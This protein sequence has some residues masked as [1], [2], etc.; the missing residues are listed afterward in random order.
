MNYFQYEI[1]TDNIGMH[2]INIPSAQPQLLFRDSY[3]GI[4]V[5]V[6]LVLLLPLAGSVGHNVAYLLLAGW[7]L[8]G[9]REALEALSLTWFLNFVN[10]G[11]Y[12]PSGQA[13]ML[14]W[15]VLGAAFLSVLRVGLL[16]PQSNRSQE[17][18]SGAW[19]GVVTFCSV[20][21]VLAVFSSYVPDVSISMLFMFFVGATTVLFG[22]ALTAHLASYWERWFL[23]FFVVI[24]AVSFPLIVHD[25][26]YV[27]NN[28]GFQGLTDHP[29]TYGV[30]LA[31][32]LSWMVA[33][34]LSGRLRGSF[35]WGVAAI[36]CISLVATQ[37]RTGAFAAVLGFTCI[38]GLKYIQ[39]PS[40]R[41]L[42]G[43]WLPRL[44][45]LALIGVASVAAYGVGIRTSVI[46]FVQKRDIEQTQGRMGVEEVTRTRRM[47]TE[48]SMDNFRESP[49]IGIGFGVRS[50]P[51]YA[52]VE[53]QMQRAGPGVT[54]SDLF[55]DSYSYPRDPV[56][57]LP[58][59]GGS[60]KGTTVTAVLE[61][62][63]VIGFMFFLG[64]LAMLLQPA[65]RSA[66][67]LAP[68]ALLL[69]AFLVNFGEAVLFS[70]GGMGM[71]I[72]LLLGLAYTRAQHASVRSSH[73]PSPPVQQSVRS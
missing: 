53:Q 25:L 14:R 70:F 21:G 52:L 10:P 1:V 73:T 66:V 32:F 31:P 41:A 38:A 12:S 68:G 15:L 27:R 40:V 64:M 42:L 37:A 11:I 50:S 18:T 35:W 7:A 46:E 8:R 45:I 34:L 2:H 24:L 29:Q 44:V 3:V 39:R 4:A 55:P 17:L 26:G 20:A 48:L 9:P 69:T 19:F 63:G 47:L 62:V 72:W 30:F 23:V 13:D 71:L 60:E 43:T 67:G 57:G 51:P 16:S 59:A 58:M 6:I 56:L 5:K 65:L 33:L 22:Y 36:T 28:Q 49:L 61:E 54:A